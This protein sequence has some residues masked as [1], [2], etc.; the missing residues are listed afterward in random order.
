MNYNSYYVTIGVVK[1]VLVMAKLAENKKSYSLTIEKEDYSKLEII[2][3]KER[4][5]VAFMINEAI[6]EY[7]KSCNNLPDK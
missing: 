4:R 3:K 1:E 6:K 7:L 2:A 5:S